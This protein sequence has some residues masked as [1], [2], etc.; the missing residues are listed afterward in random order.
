MDLTLHGEWG[1]GRGWG[2]C[3]IT[4]LLGRFSPHKEAEDNA[5]QEI[6]PLAVNECHLPS[7]SIT[8]AA[9]MNLVRVV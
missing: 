5:L 9:L 4:S 7:Q 3:T 8:V 2:V 1:G 6:R